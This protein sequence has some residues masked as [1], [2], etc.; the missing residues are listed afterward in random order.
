MNKTESIEVVN[1][2]VTTVPSPYRILLRNLSHKGVLALEVNTY[3][4]DWMSPGKWPQGTW[5]RPLIGASGTYEEE[6]PSAGRGQTTPDGY[7]PEQST[8]IEISTVVFED[9]TYEGKPYL[10]ATINAKMAGNKTQ[11]ARVIPILQTA[12]DSADDAGASVLTRLKEA[13][14]LLS[15]DADPARLKESRN[16]FPTL[17]EGERENLVNFMKVRATSCE[18]HTAKRNRGV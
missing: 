17:S 1:V 18:G 10:A 9:G 12:Q 3:S 2:E 5:D 8:G 13:T 7:V 11:S 14:S 4:G 6:M 15:D 16:R